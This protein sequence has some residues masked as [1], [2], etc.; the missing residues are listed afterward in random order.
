MLIEIIVEGRVI[1][2]TNQIATC[3]EVVRE[4]YIGLSYTIVRESGQVI[5]E[6][7]ADGNDPEYRVIH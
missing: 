4:I 6:G 3:S 7:I 2:I 5:A 1:A